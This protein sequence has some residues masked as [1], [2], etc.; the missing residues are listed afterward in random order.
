MM[1]HGE[2]PVVSCLDD[3][4]APSR[5]ALSFIDAW[6]AARRGH[7]V[8]RKQDFDPTLVPSLLPNIW[9]YRYSRSSD[10]FVCRL[11]G[12]RINSAWGYPISGKNS[13]EIFG[14]A[15]NEA[16]VA[17]WKRILGT[18]LVHYGKQ[19]RLSGNMLYSAERVVMPLSGAAD[20]RNHILGISNYA[21]GGSINLSPPAILDNAFHI[22]CRDL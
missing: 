14:E 7:L 19:E 11:A 10:E 6:K 2:L 12:E 17:I 22:H 13:R 9:I 16:V 20:E 8:P 4:P 1:L 3:L 21:L 5:A 15:D 18:P